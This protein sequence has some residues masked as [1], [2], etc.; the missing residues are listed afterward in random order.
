MQLA[1]DFPGDGFRFCVLGSGSAGNA[2][3]VQHGSDRI[4]IDCGFSAREIVRRLEVVGVSPETIGAIYLTHEHSD[5]C[6]GV[7]QF[8]KRF[9]TPVFATEGTLQAMRAGAWGERLVADR[10]VHRM[11]MEIT[12]FAVSHDAQQPVG[13]VIE[14]TR[15]GRLAVV[16]DLGHA[17]SDLWSK[18]G[19]L[20]ALILESNHDEQ[21]LNQG[22]Y[23]WSLK[24]R[25]L[26]ERGHLSNRAAAAAL[27][28]L[29]DD[30][31]HTVVL[32]HLSRTN[33]RPQLAA[34]T[35]SDT[36][37]RL[38]SPAE[39]VVSSQFEPTP[40]FDLTIQAGRRSVGQ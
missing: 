40:W 12:P 37:N 36:V 31:L 33:N 39:V 38:R 32:Y 26:G 1:L 9:E 10:P 7:R 35:V 18:V 11:D 30:R 4:L 19:T 15:G 5:H 22:P 20:D 21:M 24:R 29:A 13:F 3:L 16:A 23:P 27:K 2:I 14:G 6:R 8:R 34:D 28:Q 17:D 25:I